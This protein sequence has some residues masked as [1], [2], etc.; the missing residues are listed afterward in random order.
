M[1]EVGQGGAPCERATWGV[2]EPGGAWGL[3]SG[4][5]WNRKEIDHTGLEL[6]LKERKSIQSR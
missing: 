1:E 3:R 6:S 5:G 2:L 4:R